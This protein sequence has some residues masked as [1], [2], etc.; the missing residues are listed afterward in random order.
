MSNMSDDRWEINRISGA[1]RIC[2]KIMT[3]MPRPVGIIVSGADGRFKEEVADRIMAKLRGFAHCYCGKA[4]TADA[5]GWS[6]SRYHAVMA[7]LDFETSVSC[8]AR[9]NLVAAM[10]NSG[11]ATIVGVYAK[12]HPASPKLL[13]RVSGKAR[14]NEQISAMEK[15]RPIVEEFDYLI[16]PKEKK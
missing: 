2:D 13:T 15:N 11:A 16:I 6:L 10:R 3:R 7:V 1:E 14:L 9:R 5:L 4:P 12:A 8:E